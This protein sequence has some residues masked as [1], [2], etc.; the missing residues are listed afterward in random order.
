VAAPNE[1]KPEP[2]EPS[3]SSA[4]VRFVPPYASLRIA[5][6]LGTLPSLAVGGVLDATVA[7]EPV[8]LSVAAA[9]FYPQDE[10]RDGAGGTF[11][12]A[13]LSALPC[14]RLALGRMDILPCGLLEA[15]FIFASGEGVDQPEQ[16]FT[17]FPR[18]GLGVKLDYALAARFALVLDLL[19]FVTPARPRFVVQDDIE[20]FR[21]SAVGARFSAG[22]AVG[23]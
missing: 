20:L 8:T 5:F 16:P 10:T 23:F 22:F 9:L 14:W 2:A 17:W 4:A 18:L 1:P 15:D 19:G 21:P 6:D 11:H 3:S 7:V 13:A 12:Y